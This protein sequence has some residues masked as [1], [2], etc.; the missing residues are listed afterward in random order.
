MSHLLGFRATRVGRDVDAAGPDDV[1]VSGD[2][3]DCSHPRPVA[4]EPAVQE[5]EL[6][7]A[8][9]SSPARIGD[10]G[11]PVIDL[12]DSVDELGAGWSRSVRVPPLDRRE[13]SAI[14]G[15]R[16]TWLVDRSRSAPK[17]GSSTAVANDS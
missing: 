1:I 9:E 11:V 5:F 15:K 4:D 17:Y 7:V 6:F 16:A 3:R 10:R 13:S 8:L 12:E 14:R 2:E